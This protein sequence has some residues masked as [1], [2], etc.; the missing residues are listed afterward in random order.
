MLFLVLILCVPRL[1]T[2]DTEIRH[3]ACQCVN[4][5]VSLLRIHRA[6]SAS[7]QHALFL[8]LQKQGYRVCKLESRW[9]CLEQC[10]PEANKRAKFT[11][12]L[13]L[14]VL[15]SGQVQI[16]FLFTSLDLTPAMFILLG[17]SVR[18]A[19]WVQYEGCNLAKIVTLTRGLVWLNKLIMI[20]GQ[21][22]NKV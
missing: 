9:V 7:T 20:Q 16:V 11:P 17:F 12:P 13:L 15:C 3:P 18:A 1:A 4:T 19:P 21:D 2:D 6:L 22:T 14:A 5:A 8:C 10:V